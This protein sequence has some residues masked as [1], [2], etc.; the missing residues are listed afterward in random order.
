MAFAI[1]K[2]ESWPLQAFSSNPL[3]YC[4]LVRILPD[5]VLPYVPRFD[6]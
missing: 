6:L 2:I 3:I 4:Q 1:A 5:S